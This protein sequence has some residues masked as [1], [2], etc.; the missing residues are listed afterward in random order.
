M[1]ILNKLKFIYFKYY[2]IVYYIFNVLYYKFKFIICYQ[3]K[4]INFNL[5]FYYYYIFINI[6]QLVI[7]QYLISKIIIVFLLVFNKYIFDYKN[8]YS[9]VITKFKYLKDY[10]FFKYLNMFSGYF[11][12]KRDKYLFIMLYKLLHVKRLYQLVISFFIKAKDIIPIYI[13]YYK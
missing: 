13:K 5:L 11:F 6:I 7:I 8:N 1:L 3:N 10:F 4:M 9:I 12:I 2:Y